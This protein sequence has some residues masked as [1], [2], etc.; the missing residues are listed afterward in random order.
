MRVSQH[1]HGRCGVGAA[2]G[3]AADGSANRWPAIGKGEVGRWRARRGPL[4]AGNWK[5]NGLQALGGR[6]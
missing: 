4:I 3:A 6:A 1:W 5:M 2:P